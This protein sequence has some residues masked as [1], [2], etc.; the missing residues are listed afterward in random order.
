MVANNVQTKT[1]DERVE[2]IMRQ[3]DDPELMK[4]RRA[5][6]VAR[7]RAYEEQF[8]MRSEDI[9]DAIERGDLTETLDVCRWIFDYE[10]LSR[11]KVR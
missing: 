5:E 3:R 10:S 8:G 1:I 4:Q 6:T 7:V 2:E 9:H 11:A